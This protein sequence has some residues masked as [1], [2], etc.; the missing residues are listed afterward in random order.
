M[1]SYFVPIVSYI[2]TAPGPAISVDLRVI[3]S[4]CHLPVRVRNT[5]GGDSRCLFVETVGIGGGYMSWTERIVSTEAELFDHD[6][7]RIWLDSISRGQ[8]LGELRGP[9]VGSG[10]VPKI[11]SVM[12]VTRR[13]G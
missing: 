12:L 7:F 11:T 9:E 8:P 3:W 10:D 4:R 6:V 2:R 5:L 1:H 13:V